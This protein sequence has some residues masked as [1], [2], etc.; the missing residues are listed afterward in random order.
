L[1]SKVSN[2]WRKQRTFAVQNSNQMSRY[3]L[4]EE[5]ANTLTHA[6]GIPFGI[7][8]FFLFF[9]NNFGADNYWLLISTLVYAAFM[10]FS[11]ITS[12][13]YHNQRAE[14]KKLLLRKFDHAAIYL[15]IAGSYTPFTLVVLRNE[16]YWGWTLFGIIW[17]AALAGVLLSFAKLKNASKLE[18]ACYVAMGWV[19]VIAFKPLIDVLSA[20]GSMLVFWWL[21]A[22]GLSYTVGAIIYSIKK[23][24]FMHA[25]W[26]LFVLGGSICHAIAIS[27]ISA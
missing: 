1:K 17:L 2:Y 25:V 22:G 11:Y 8:V 14:S 15:H 3:T 5:K 9:K 18:T 23:I 10:T 12:T 6:I 4:R 13:L 20:S 24:E 27:L 26:H 16:G 21:V 19:V 7:I